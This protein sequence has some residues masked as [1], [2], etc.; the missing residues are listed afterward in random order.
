[1]PSLSLA[2]YTSRYS[3]RNNT[4]HAPDN[5]GITV[6]LKGHVMSKTPSLSFAKYTSRYSPRNT[7][8]DVYQEEKLTG[9][10]P[11]IELYRATKLSVDDLIADYQEMTLLA[12]K[13]AA[14]TGIVQTPS[15]IAKKLLALRKAGKLRKTRV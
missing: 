10:E 2:K 1:M 4:S 3:P 8:F 5:F 14:T 13:L 12:L 7:L 11:L 6:T 9:D 15:K